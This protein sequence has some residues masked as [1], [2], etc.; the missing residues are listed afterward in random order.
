[1]GSLTPLRT[2]TAKETEMAPVDSSSERSSGHGEGSGT[3]GGPS[4]DDRPDPSVEYLGFLLGEEAYGVSV[5]EVKEVIRTMEILEVP[6]VP[7]FVR[8]VISLR[9]TILPVFDIKRRMGFSDTP[10]TSRS[11]II[12]ISLNGISYGL[13]ADAVFGVIPVDPDRVESPP[14]GLKVP[15]DFLNG[16]I[17]YTGVSVPLERMLILL[18]LERVVAL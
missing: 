4:G 1:M 10:F 13:L 5:S 2:M 6:R 18:N 7:G 15:P 12:V 9:G 16:V 14:S 17:H 11:R 8:G 3:G